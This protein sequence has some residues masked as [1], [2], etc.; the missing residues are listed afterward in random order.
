VE[1]LGSPCKGQKLERRAAI[2]HNQFHEVG[3]LRK[4]WRE[5][6]GNKG[7]VTNLSENFFPD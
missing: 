6:D 7:K 1:E 2:S 5:E 3:A 4:I